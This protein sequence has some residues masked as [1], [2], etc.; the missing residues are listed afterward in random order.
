MLNLSFRNLCTLACMLL[1][2]FGAYAQEPLSVIDSMR[3]PASPAFK[4]IGAEPTSVERP[5]DL[6][7]L[8]IDLS[9]IG[10]SGGALPTQFAMEFGIAKLFSSGRKGLFDYYF[11]S[12]GQT[13]IDNLSI[14]LATGAIPEDMFVDTSFH[15]S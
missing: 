12:I 13:M 5:T 1:C 10:A 6:K 3:V 7:A 14:S 8:A 11:P 2:S 9:T 15:A 4:I